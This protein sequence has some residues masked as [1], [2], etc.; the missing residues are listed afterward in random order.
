MV[1]S[2][3]RGVW[4]TK[5]VKRARKSNRA[6]NQEGSR[7]MPKQGHACCPATV[8]YRLYSKKPAKQT[9]VQM[10]AAGR[11]KFVS[12]HEPRKSSITTTP[13]QNHRE[14]HRS[15]SSRSVAARYWHFSAA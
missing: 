12:S 6:I 3:E 11:Y 2:P 5:S 4:Q 1:R 9:I 15:R 14:D 7:T 13:V 10:R 8:W